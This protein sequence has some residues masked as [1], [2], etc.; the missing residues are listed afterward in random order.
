MSTKPRNSEWIILTGCV[1]ALYGASVAAL[2]TL[3][4]S[5]V[6]HLVLGM[7][8]GTVVTLATAAA[9][10]SISGV[11]RQYDVAA[12]RVKISYIQFGWV[13][14]ALSVIVSTA[15]LAKSAYLTTL[16]RDEVTLGTIRGDF[17]QTEDFRSLAGR[18]TGQLFM[19]FVCLTAIL[20]RF[21]G[22]KLQLFVAFLITATYSL[23]MGGRGQIV[24][25]ALALVPSLIVRVS[26]YGI[27]G[28]AGCLVMLLGFVHEIRTP[29]GGQGIWLSIGQYLSTPW[30]G[31]DLLLQGKHSIGTPNFIQTGAPNVLEEFPFPVF[32]NYG[33]L[34]GGVGQLLYEF[35]W[36][37]AGLY[38]SAVVLTFC[39]AG[40]LSRNA[41]F[42]R[43]GLQSLAFL[44][45]TFFLFHDLTVFYPSFVLALM[46]V[47]LGTFSA[48]F[49]SLSFR[50]F[51]QI[52]SSTSV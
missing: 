18:I 51:G 7:L 25:F 4:H 36:L 49:S 3:S 9:M 50:F 24:F 26:P 47:L 5:V 40:W 39:I 41:P 11:Y 15:D 20:F 42:A 16:V 8:V 34:F 28:V 38:F 14:C 35:G 27:L 17:F 10:W 19:P 29:G 37:G 22:G 12:V 52:R 45:F 48:Q 13:M 44:Y 31:I 32:G 33:N 6:E 2:A 30:M 46:T 21:T 1:A 23:L 43:A